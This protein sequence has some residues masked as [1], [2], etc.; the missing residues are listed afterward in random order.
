MTREDFK[1]VPK[2][3]ATSTLTMVFYKETI[4]ESVE[5]FKNYRTFEDEA[6]KAVRM[7]EGTSKKTKAKPVKMKSDKDKRT[8]QEINSECERLIFK[9][10]RINS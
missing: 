7:L 3:Y 9:Y 10:I 2:H 1:I 5:I 4:I 8:L 6:D